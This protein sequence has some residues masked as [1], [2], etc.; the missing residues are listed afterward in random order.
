MSISDCKLESY[1]ACIHDDSWFIG[2]M[3]EVSD[4]HQDLQVKFMAK[5]LNNNFNW[6]LGDDIWW[7]PVSHVLS[8]VILLS[9]QLEGTNGY[10]LSN[11]EFNKVI[12]LCDEFSASSCY[13]H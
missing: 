10:C 1:V 13:T 9:V 12:N 5:P 4:Q 7:V 3:T 11:C 6:P 8:T 2:N